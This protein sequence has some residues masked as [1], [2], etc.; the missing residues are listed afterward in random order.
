MKKNL[1]T[2]IH[3]LLIAAVMLAVAAC[4]E[5]DPLSS[6]AVVKSVKVNGVSAVSVGTPSMDW[7]QAAENPGHVFINGELLNNA[8][9][10]VTASAGSTVFLAQAKTSVQPYFVAEKVFS[11]ESEDILYVEVFSENHDKFMIYAI[12]VHNRKPGLLDMTLDGKSAMGGKTIEGR[13]IPSFGD[14][15]TPADTAEGATAGEIMFDV[16][17]LANSLDITL[18]PEVLSTKARVTTAAEGAAP[19]FTGDSVGVTGGI[20]SDLRINPITDGYIYIE[21]SGDGDNYGTSFYKLKMIAKNNDRSIKSAK[22]VWYNGTT[23]IDEK[24]VV[25]GR[26]G[27]E[28]W[29]GGEAYG[30]YNNGAEVAGGG[31]GDSQTMPAN[32][33]SFVELYQDST[34]TRPPENFRLTLELEGN[35]PD[36][37]FAYDFSKNQR[38]QPAFLNTTGDFGKLIG[39]YWIAVEVTSGMGEKGWY[40]F[41]SMIGSEKTDLGSIKINNTTIPAASFPEGNKSAG[42]ATS[43]F[44]KWTVPANT[45]MD[46]LKIEVAPPAGYYSRIAIIPAVDQYTNAATVLYNM[47]EDEN[48]NSNTGINATTLSL[49]SGQFI[50]IRLL[51][52]ISWFYGGSGFVSATWC[53]AVQA[54]QYTAYKYYKVQVVKEGATSDVEIADIK[55]KGASIGTVPT[56]L[57]VTTNQSNLFDTDYKKNV[58]VTTTTT[59]TWAGDAKVYNT[60]DFTDVSLSVTPGASS[61]NLRFA[62]AI[63]AT[64]P[65]APIAAADF[66]TT[67]RF[68]VLESNTYIVIRATSED[69]TNTKF[70]KLHLLSSVGPAYAPSAIK[71]NG[72][73]ISA[74]GDGNALATGDV[75]VPYNV[76]NSAA[77]N[78]ITVSVD[79]PNPSVSV[80][81]A[82]VDPLALTAALPTDDDPWVNTSGVFNNVAP[83]Q[84]VFIRTIAAD[85][86]QTRFYKVRLLLA[87]ANDQAVLTDIK[88]NST[89]IS[90]VPEPNAAVTGTNNG[91]HTL[92]SAQELNNMQVTVTASAGATVAYASSNA[93]NTN[94]QDWSNT[95][96]VFGIFINDNYLYIR[97]NSENGANTQFYKVRITAPAE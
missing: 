54:T 57:T 31:T 59:Q 34:S 52:E 97:V 36:L 84:Y 20:I 67:G 71:I 15:G 69:G 93:N 66:N 58:I 12:V 33:T 18:T 80:A 65:T 76:P 10:D 26:M 89:S 38:S 78:Q 53:P 42:D 21:V 64:N 39:F 37:K 13:P 40:K 50:H 23:K 29:S 2:G 8:K 85:R 90:A 88:I 77:F 11:F 45:D 94:I 74:V 62:Y 86:T 6:D 55:Y 56:P 60:A 91:T 22:F 81:Y 73:N 32:R 14:L 17:K 92:A 96:G 27:T 1:K 82:L 5:P 3:L 35:D 70:Y 7:M 72:V 16:A 28:S 83:G 61:P 47:N 4:Q 9:V 30:N 79:K 44:L 87:G 25:V 19:V 41:A 51:A 68:G 63:S 49:T 95:T 48:Y 75:F 24:V 46:N 43:G